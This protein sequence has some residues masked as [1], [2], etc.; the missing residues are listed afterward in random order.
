[1]LEETNKALEDKDWAQASELIKAELEKEPE[2]EKL[3]HDL[4]YNQ[5]ACSINLKWFKYAKYL[6]EK[7]TSLFSA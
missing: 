5:I 3:L 6:T 4:V 7:N 1:M 2:D